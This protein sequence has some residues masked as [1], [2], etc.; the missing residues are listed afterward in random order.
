MHGHLT[1]L[2]LLLLLLHTELQA[3]SGLKGAY[4][5]VILPSDVNGEAQCSQPIKHVL[6][7]EVN[8]CVASIIGLEQQKAWRAAA[9]ARTAQLPSASP[10]QQPLFSPGWSGGA[11]PG[12]GS[13][14]ELPKPKSLL[15]QLNESTAAFEAIQ[16]QL[17]VLRHSSNS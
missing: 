5:P 6:K 8:S 17:N 9:A 2:L 16:Q 4:A 11:A 12:D 13:D 15:E 7:I 1:W 3:N 14:R 10:N